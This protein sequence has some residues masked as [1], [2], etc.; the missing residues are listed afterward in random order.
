MTSILNSLK[1]QTK[2]QKKKI[3]KLNQNKKS[4]KKIKDQ[5]KLI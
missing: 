1:D 2:T 3:I 5:Y 4:Q